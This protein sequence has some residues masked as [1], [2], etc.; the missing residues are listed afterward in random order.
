MWRGG[1]AVLLELD[2]HNFAIIE[3]ISLDF[4]QGMTVLTG[5]TGAGKSIIIDAVG[6]LAGG[7]GSADYVRHGANKCVLE[8]QFTSP[9][10]EYLK[11]LL[12]RESI[13]FD[14][15][16][17]IIQREIYQ[18]GRSVCRVNGSLVT[19]S[20]L[21]EIGAFLIDIH[22]QNEHQE[23]M[24]SENHG[25][26]LDYFGDASVNALKESYQKD[27][28]AYKQTERR[29][30]EWQNKEQEIAQ[31]IDVLRFQ[32]NEIAEANL[33][34]GEEEELEEEERRLANFQNIMEALTASYQVL[35]ENDLNALEMVGKA[36][37][38]ME[39]IED[40]DQH[41]KEISESLSATFFQLQEVASEIYN[42]MDEQEYDE[43]RLNEIS[44][45]LNLIQQLKRKY[46]NS[47]PEILA[48]YE[49]SME[50]LAVIENSS[51]SKSELADKM[52]KLEKSMVE[53]GKQLSE[54]RRD[55]ARDLEAAIHEQLKALY[56]DKA[57]F[58]VQFQKEVNELSI[59]TA[60]ATGLDQIEFF[61]STNPGE[62]LKPL[63]KVASG[64]ELSRMMLALKTIFAKSQGITSIIFDEIDTGVSGRV[65]QAIAEKIYSISVHSQVLCITHLP[66][67]AAIADYH[68]YVK[69]AMIEERTTTAAVILKDNDR[70]EEIARMLSG[71]ETTEVAMQA[72]EALIKN[73]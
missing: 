35:R 57:S 51:Q 26:L 38:E 59:A 47:I 17:I 50:E 21:K 36:M 72:A 27:Y 42:E 43:N 6:L 34:A 22:G 73:D 5:E 37:D 19:I 32:T 56:M 39:D 54:K 70:V 28:K 24:Q 68:L 2:I 9:K 44:S 71:S 41:L 52:K 53:K 40:V 49:E 62:P 29:F 25:Q 23:L 45:R 7:R 33:V 20:L 8:G 11:E 55:V 46:G 61:I 69:K 3:D 64:G 1:I 58:V 30:N 10:N 63:T 14:D 65:A 15:E 66:Q 31:K 60:K 4:E 13:E 16:V 18:T 48:H 67:V 12:A